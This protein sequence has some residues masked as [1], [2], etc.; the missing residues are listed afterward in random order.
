M[1]GSK[2]LPIQLRQP[3][4]RWT[5]FRKTS[6]PV[7][8]TFFPR[9]ALDARR[10]SEA[11][12]HFPGQASCP[13]REVIRH[14]SRTALLNASLS[15]STAA[16]PE[17]RQTTGKG[18][19]NI[20]MLGTPRH[21]RSQDHSETSHGTRRTGTKS[22]RD[23]GSRRSASRIDRTGAERRTREPRERNTRSDH[24]ST[25]AVAKVPFV[26]LESG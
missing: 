15:G 1:A 12:G 17:L 20:G 11:G 9:K 4:H 24:R 6:A 14:G 22:L 13:I 10:C 2:W 16:I 5:P 19:E 3:C 8:R 23:V 21:E 25:R 7:Q 18:T 26:Q